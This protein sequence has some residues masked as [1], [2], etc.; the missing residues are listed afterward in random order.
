MR[1]TYDIFPAKDAQEY[2][3][4]T[5][6]AYPWRSM[7]VGDAFFVPCLPLHQSCVRRRITAANFQFAR[8]NRQTQMKIKLRPA[9]RDGKPGLLVERVA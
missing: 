8:Y 1:P 4:P 6:R 3:L 5:Y 2:V 7:K 9:M